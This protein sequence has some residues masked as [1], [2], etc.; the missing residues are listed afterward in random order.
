MTTLRHEVSR[1]FISDL[2]SIS[3]DA[4]ISAC[5]D[6]ASKAS[7]VLEQQGVPGDRQK[8]QFQADMRYKGQALTLPINFELQ[9]IETKGQ[10]E[11]NFKVLEERSSRAC[12]VAWS[13][14]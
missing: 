4:F 14:N 2:S 7:L 9:D 3:T 11:S 13:L 5:S 10:N 6:L 1:T 12:R 8:G